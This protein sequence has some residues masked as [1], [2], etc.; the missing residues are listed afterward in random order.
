[1]AQFCHTITKAAFDALCFEFRSTIPTHSDE[2]AWYASHEGH[3]AAVLLKYEHDHYWGWLVVDLTDGRCHAIE[4]EMGFRDVESAERKIDHALG[5]L[6][7]R[8]M[9][10]APLIDQGDRR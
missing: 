1:M 3:Y 9:I 6:E 8:K 2:L 4:V 5:S 7:R 10:D